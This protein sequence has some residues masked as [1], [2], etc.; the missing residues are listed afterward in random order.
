MIVVEIV[1]ELYPAPTQK[2]AKTHRSTLKP[3]IYEIQ[4]LN[5]RQNAKYTLEYLRR[6]IIKSNKH[7]GII[8]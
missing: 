6:V 3:E 2:L 8:R 4:T 7:T 5:T 1:C